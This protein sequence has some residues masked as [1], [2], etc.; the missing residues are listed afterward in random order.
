[1][2]VSKTC[3]IKGKGGAQKGGKERRRKGGR[4]E[5][6]RETKHKAEGLERLSRRNRRELENAT[7]RRKR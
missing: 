1:M 5:G 4:G 3:H 6:S 2:Y 7:K